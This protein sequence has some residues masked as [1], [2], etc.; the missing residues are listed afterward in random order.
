MAELK[1]KQGDNGLYGFVDENDN[2]VVEPK[3]AGTWDSREGLAAFM[4]DWDQ[5][6][7]VD[8][9]GTVVIEPKYDQVSN[10]FYG[11]AAV[12]TEEDGGQIIDTKGNVVHEIRNMGL[13]D[14]DPEERV[15]ETFCNV[16]DQEGNAHDLSF[17]DE[18]WVDNMLEWEDFYY[19][20]DYDEDED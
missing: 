17:E 13:F 11:N 19:N 10:F 3:Y 1:S 15:L 9:E 2:W 4:N 20:R 18:D 14:M 16:W 12:Y 7:F 5:C 6:G 8:T